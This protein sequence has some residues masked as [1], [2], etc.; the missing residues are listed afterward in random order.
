MSIRTILP[1][2]HR[3]LLTINDAA[4][5]IDA[6]QLLSGRHTS[7]VI[8]CGPNGLM[9]GVVTKADIVR[10]ISTCTGC[11]CTTM[12]SDIMTRE[13]IAC[14]PD[15]KLIDVWAIMRDNAL[16]QIPV[17]DLESRP[18]GLLYA[19]DALEVLLKE[20]E[21]EEVLLREYVMGIGYR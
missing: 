10:Q 7:L 14:H 9:S 20:V 2:A 18:L 21:Y 13:V 3:R 6:A 16:R 11:S 4:P 12:V 15:D 17:S 8:V 19:S 5:V 1:T